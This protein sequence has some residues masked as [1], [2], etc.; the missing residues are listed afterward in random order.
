MDLSK[1]FYLYHFDSVYIHV[2]FFKQFRSICILFSECFSEVNDLRKYEAILFEKK[3]YVQS[4]SSEKFLADVRS[5]PSDDFLNFLLIDVT[6]FAKYC[7]K[8]YYY[9]NEECAKYMELLGFFLEKY[10]S[11]LMLK[12]ESTHHVLY[13][14]FLL[15]N[16]LHEN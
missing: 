2:S 15:K 11:I 12:Q 1:I 16:I 13:L 3:T 7:F 10:S 14:N 5:D 8:G 9:N 4:K 6:R